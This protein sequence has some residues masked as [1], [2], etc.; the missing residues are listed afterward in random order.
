LNEIIIAEQSRQKDRDLAVDQ[1]QANILIEYE[2][3]LAKLL[4]DNSIDL[5]MS[6]VAK[7]VATTMTLSALSQLDTRRKSILLRS[8]YN[9]KLITLKLT[10]K[11]SDASILEFVHIDLSDLTLGS[12]RDSP[13]QRA[14]D[15]YIDWNYLYLPYSTLTNTSFRHALLDCATFELAD[16]N[17]VDLSLATQA[18]FKCFGK[19]R[20]GQTNFVGASLIKANLSKAHFRF[21]TF[22][23][24]DL[25]LANMRGFYCL[26]CYFASAKLFQAD[27][28][29][30]MIFQ[31]F[32][33]DQEKL[34]FRAANLSQAITHST[35][36]RSINFDKSDWSN[37]QA[38]QILIGNSTFGNAIMKNCSFVKSTI[39]ECVFRNAS[40][41]SIDLSDAVLSNVSFVNSDMR[42]AN[43]SYIKC[44]H[45]DFT[46]VTLQSAVLKNASLRHSNFL[47]CRVNASQLE[48][49]IDLSGSTLPNGTV[50]ESND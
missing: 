15:R 41:V 1:Q 33:A 10:S 25:T 40:L 12:L 30:S 44:N 39:L 9:A 16:M 8:L 18:N 34:D 31:G 19:V 45:C 11:Q 42:N 26:E 23:G 47:N 13:D 17:S 5:N 48:E 38:S 37:V 29:F 22:S 4:L 28:S 50:V 7:V 2:S 20:R 14:K 43:M 35:M 27:S 32:V 6:S 46:N 36:F 21:T 3:F 24:T 49:A